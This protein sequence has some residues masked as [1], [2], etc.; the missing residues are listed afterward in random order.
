ML[1]AFDRARN[2]WA[3]VPLCDQQA[4]AIQ[5][6]PSRPAAARV[7]SQTLSLTT[8]NIQA[9]QPKPGERAALILDHI[10]QGPQPPDI[11]FLQE[12]ASRARESVLC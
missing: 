10:L 4:P 11:V 12:V 5:R 6:P 7:G 2:R 9:S 8:W 3:A 1:S